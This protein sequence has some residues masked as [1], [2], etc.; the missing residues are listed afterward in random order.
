MLEEGALWNV[1]F[2]DKQLRLEVIGVACAAHQA[3]WEQETARSHNT[4]ALHS[5]LQAAQVCMCVCVCRLVRQSLPTGNAVGMHV[6]RCLC[7]LAVAASPVLAASSS[8]ALGA[9]RTLTP[10][11]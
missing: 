6:T 11:A 5:A 2:P 10:R 8:A 7:W 1:A 3:L 4:R 9:L